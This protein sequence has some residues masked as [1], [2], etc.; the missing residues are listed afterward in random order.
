MGRYTYLLQTYK[1]EYH[2]AGAPADA[3][4]KGEVSAG[5]LLSLCSDISVQISCIAGAKGSI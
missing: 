3:E 2:V 1:S 5:V 4:N